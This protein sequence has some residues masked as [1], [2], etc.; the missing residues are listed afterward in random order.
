MS[1]RRLLCYLAL[2]SLLALLCVALGSVLNPAALVRW[3]NQTQAH[4]ALRAFWAM[5]GIRHLPV[6]LLCIA[7]GNLIFTAMKDA[8]RSRAWVV[9]TPYLLYVL[10][11]AIL[12]SLRAGE[13]AF[14][15]LGYD[16]SYFIWPHFVFVPA[17][18]IAAS[19]MVRQRNHRKSLTPYAGSTECPERRP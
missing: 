17:G 3:E 14:S 7:A 2:G 5:I 12:D 4:D 15:W 6:F 1:T 19:R 8:A 16:P 9:S 13:T 11:T 18:L 10:V